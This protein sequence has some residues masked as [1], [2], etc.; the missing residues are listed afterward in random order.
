MK[1]L[2][3]SRAKRAL[4]LL[5]S[6]WAAALSPAIGA[7]GKCDD[8]A[9]DVRQAVAKDPS[10]VLMI[11]ED[12]LVISE[13]CACE[14]VKA[15]IIASNADQARVK[16]IVQTAMAV[17]PKQSA[18]IAECAAAATAGGPVVVSNTS[19]TSE[20]DDGKNPVSG[21]NPAGGKNTLSGKNI[22]ASAK[23]PP[24]E[25]SPVIPPEAE[26]TEFSGTPVSI[27]GIY[28]IQPAAAGFLTIDES[29]ICPEDEHDDDGDDHEQANSRR[30]RNLIDI[31]PAYAAVK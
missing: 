30:K 13:E 17:A 23:N 24:A 15:A 26:G 20:E 8:I 22:V 2:F 31:S 19:E 12:A 3:R 14:I 5:G 1:T 27:R 21:K 28:L 29:C 10:K 4:I 25:A 11:V 16:E 6:L 9:K 18:I 7:P